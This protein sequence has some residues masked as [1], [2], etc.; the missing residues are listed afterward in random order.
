MRNIPAPIRLPAR[1]QRKNKTTAMTVEEEEEWI[2]KTDELT[3]AFRFFSCC[4]LC[5]GVI[6]WKIVAIVEIVV[7]IEKKATRTQKKRK[8]KNRTTLIVFERFGWSQPR[9]FCYFFFL[10]LSSPILFCYRSQKTVHG[11]GRVVCSR[12]SILFFKRVL[13]E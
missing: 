3:K 11:E 5:S 2:K 10:R 8:W 6:K 13:R 12:L 9:N 4:D 7:E 1:A